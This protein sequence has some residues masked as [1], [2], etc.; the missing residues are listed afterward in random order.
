MADKRDLFPE[1]EPYDTGMLK[2]SDLHSIYYEESGN[3]NGNPVVFIHGGPGGGTSPRDR[4]FFD[5]EAY[6]IILFDQRGAGQSLPAYELRENTTW[7]LVAD[8]EK[9]REHLKIDKWVVFGGSWGSTLGLAYS[10]THPDKVKAIILRG[11]FTCRRRELLW[12]Y[13]DGTSLIYPDKF[14]AYR[15]HIPEVERGDLISAYYRRLTGDDKEARLSAAQAWSTWEMTTS[16]MYV[17]E[18]LVKKAEKDTW[19]LQFARIECHY[20]VNGIFMKTETQLLDD[21]VKLSNIPVTIIQGRY[22][23]I[24]PVETAWLLHK[25]LPKADFHIVQDAGHSTKEEG[26]QSQ[27]I[28]A[29]EKYKKL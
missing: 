19:C 5:P 28:A 17:D 2:V 9:L 15:D 13:Q 6:R 1:I 26:I 23:V 22:D 24:C 20:F 18:E 10:E 4:R 27:L 3:K 21:A 7:D 14:E 25:K 29:T 8:I 12:F 11:I 16:R